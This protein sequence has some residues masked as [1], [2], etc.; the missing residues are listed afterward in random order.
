MIAQHRRMPKYSM[1]ACTAPFLSILLVLGTSWGD[2][3]AGRIPA[4][5]APATIQPESTR[6]VKKA[7]VYLKVQMDGGDTAEGSGFFA[8]EPGIVLTNAH[9]LGMLQKNSKAPKK[10][11]VV[12][13]SGQADEV[14]MTARV[15]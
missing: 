5:Q 8:M 13:N 11:E 2:E 9:V 4:R 7:T 6:K 10:V 15:L 3:P 14:S 12:A 1:V